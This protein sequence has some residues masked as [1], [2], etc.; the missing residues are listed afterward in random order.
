M[1]DLGKETTVE[2]PEY[3]R[4]A[5]DD[6]VVGTVIETDSDL[7]S[8]RVEWDDGGT[9]IE[10]LD[11]EGEDWTACLT[12][13]KAEECLKVVQ[14][15]IDQKYEPGWEPKLYAPGHEGPYWNI[16]LEGAGEWAIWIGGRD[17][18]PFPDGVFTE[19]GTSWYLALYPAN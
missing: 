4:L 11:G 8:F 19:P 6:R 14:K 3:V 12:R 5:A 10:M 18:T 9:S 17:E 16:S 2:F 15:Y 13:A 7:R 1:I